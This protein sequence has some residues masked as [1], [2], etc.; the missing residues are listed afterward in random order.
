MAK[1]RRRKPTAHKP[2]RKEKSRAAREARA[3]R[4]IIGGAIAV[5]VL[6]IGVL[7]YGYISEVIIK[8][9]QPVATVNGEEIPAKDWQARVR[10]LR[11]RLEIQLNAYQQQRMAIDPSAPSADLYIQQLDQEIRTLQT[12]LSEEYRVQIGQQVLQQMAQ[13]EIY[14]QEA[15]RLGISVTPGEVDQSIE[16]FFGYDRSDL[17]SSASPE[18]GAITDTTTTTPTT[19][20]TEEEFETQYDDYINLVLKPT[21]L[22]VEGFRA[23]MEASLLGQKI[24][25]QVTSSV[26]A[27]DEQVDI[28]YI[29]YPSEEGG[30]SVLERLEQGEEWEAI[31]EEIEA[32]EEGAAYV[33]DMEWRTEQYLQDQFGEEI[34]QAVFAADVGSLLGPLEGQSGRFYVIEVLGHETRELDQFM[35][36]YAESAAFEDWLTQR[37]Q[38]VEYSENWQEKLPSS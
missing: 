28:R 9:R 18:T 15:E 10:E 35:L 13:E 12:Q 22:G 30:A 32:D 20:M 2:T 8:G 5:G 25:E 6:L 34:G 14:R 33:T 37:M 27:E 23:M 21:G 36:S 26:P 4:W 19:G 7:A 1:R 17:A 38:G 16:Q 3:T 31:Q 24:R 29:A 11:R